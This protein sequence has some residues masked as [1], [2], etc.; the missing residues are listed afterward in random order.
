MVTPQTYAL[1]WWR[2]YSVIY[3]ECRVWQYDLSLNVVIVAYQ[4][5]C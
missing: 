2:D 4:V 1:F 3:S 5:G